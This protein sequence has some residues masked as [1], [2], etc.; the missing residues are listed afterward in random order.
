M[1]EPGRFF[2]VPSQTLVV[3]IQSKVIKRNEMGEEILNYY[4]TDGIHQSFN[5]K[6]VGKYLRFI[7]FLKKLFES[8]NKRWESSK[9]AG[10]K[11]TS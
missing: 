10:C 9:P 2:V 8:L 7:Y 1:A 4:I 11:T 5:F 3:N 6:A